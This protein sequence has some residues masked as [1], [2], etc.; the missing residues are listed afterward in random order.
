M[1]HDSF[2]QRNDRFV[3]N[4]KRIELPNLPPGSYD[5]EYNQATGDLYFDKFFPNY[6]SLIDLPSPEF[7]FVMQRVNMFLDLETRQKFKEY[8]YLYKNSFLLHGTHGTGKTC[9]VNRVGEKVIE[10]GGVIIFN[11]HPQLISKMFSILEDVQPGRTT[12]VIF[13]EFETLLQR[14]EGHLLS[15][16]D[17]EIQK[18]NVMFLATTNHFDKIPARL[19]RPGRFGS[20]LEVKFPNGLARKVYLERKLKPDDY[21][22]IPEWVLKTEGF[23]IDELKETVLAVKC[24]GER[25]DNVVNRIRALRDVTPVKAANDDDSDESESKTII[26]E[27]G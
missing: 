7:D 18:D 15:V 9:I 21:G 5:L 2:E 24:L 20:I 13:E 10:K 14:H 23:S 26:V 27:I 6:D 3:A 22:Q 4:S 16:L 8:G 1:N 12:M 11:P 17:G 19:R 25:L